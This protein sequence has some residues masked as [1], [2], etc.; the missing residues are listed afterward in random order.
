MSAMEGIPELG[1]RERK[2][3]KTREAVRRE[4]FRLFE[5]HGYADTTV[6]QIAEAAN[7][8]PRT[9]FRY[10]PNKSEVL[11]PDHLIDHILDHFV[12]APNNLHPVAA[13]RHALEEVLSGDAG[14]E[15]TDE[16]AR[17]RLLHTL[18]E[19]AGALYQGYLR[20][21]DR[22]AEALAA[23]RGWPTPDDDMYFLASA[24]IGV[25][26]GALHGTTMNT[27]A[28]FGALRFLE[29]RMPM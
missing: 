18:P 3:I 13:Y 15:W 1:L 20:T 19:A 26:M 28:I 6:D 4:A 9:F 16:L 2:K 27:D 5:T 10:F 8:S 21:K 23:R 7:V 29:N 22:I 12:A 14:D 17:Q 24:M 11:I 25:M